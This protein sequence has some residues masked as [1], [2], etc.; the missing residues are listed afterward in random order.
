MEPEVPDRSAA[1]RLGS[2]ACHDER[3][4]PS[5]S[6][7]SPSPGSDP[8]TSCDAIL[9]VDGRLTRTLELTDSVALAR[10]YFAELLQ[11]T[12]MKPLAPLSVSSAMDPALPGFSAIQELTTSHASFHYFAPTTSRPAPR[13]HL[14]LFSCRAFA[15][16]SVLQIAARHLHLA[17]WAATYVVRSTAVLDRQTWELEGEG[18][19]VR[20]SC[21]LLRSGSARSRSVMTAPGER[22]RSGASGY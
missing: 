12:S 9:V 2:N 20:Q 4:F 15:L 1:G 8:G 6:Q 22:L 18:G 13:V 21:R 10:A 19:L 17:E 5:K 7:G 14:D 16:E 11:A 3:L